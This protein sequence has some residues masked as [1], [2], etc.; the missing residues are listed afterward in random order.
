MRSA[1]EWKAAHDRIPLA[2]HL[3][4]IGKFGWIESQS[5]EYRPR[6]LPVR[7]HAV[8]TQFGGD[9]QDWLVANNLA[10]RE[11]AFH[12]RHVFLSDGPAHELLC[13]LFCRF[14]VLADKH[15]AAGQPI[16]PVA[17]ERIPL[18]GSLSAHDLYYAVV[19]VASSRVHRNPGRFVDDDHVIVLMHDADRLG[20]Y[21]WLVSVEGMGYHVAI[22]DFES[23][24]RNGFAVDLDLPG[25][26]RIF[27]S[28]SVDVFSQL[29][30]RVQ[31]YIIFLWPVSKLIL[32]DIQDLSAPPS[33]FHI[34]VISEV[35][36]RYSSETVFEIVWPR[37][38]ITWGRNY[39]RRR[40][41]TFGCGNRR[42]DDGQG[43]ARR[44]NSPA[45]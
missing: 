12:S 44:W 3:S 30:T 25:F 17:R 38:G 26:N 7:A 41:E 21:R 22:F 33:L 27:L 43:H 20:G 35:I 2:F 5:L 45:A 6:L 36:R 37:P 29:T 23:R 40:L 39:C 10:F 19:V 14:F 13:E 31:S 18:M 42:F 32:E 28:V 1:G 15:D 16:E 8:E 24:P 34:C 11:F 9:L 4:A